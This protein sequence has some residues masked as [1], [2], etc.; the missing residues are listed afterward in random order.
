MTAVISNCGQ[1]RYR[2]ERQVSLYGETAAVI[3]VNPSTA[4]AANDDP[5]IRRIIGFAK[6]FGWSRVIVGNLF[7]YRTPNVRQLAHIPDPVGP[8]NAEH[9]ARILM[10][11]H[12]TVV[13]WGP[14]SKLP[15]ALRQEWRRLQALANSLDRELLCLGTAADGHPR[16]PLMLPKDAT[17]E[18]WI[19]PA[20]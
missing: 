15:R 9:L 10:E 11:A 1:F 14:T 8:D 19:S 3:M 6:S 13:A 7:A 4:D 20:A 5:T 12:H 17:I 2:L 16:H 18:P